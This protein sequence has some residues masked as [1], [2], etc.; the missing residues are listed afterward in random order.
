MDDVATGR[1]AFAEGVECTGASA[2]VSGA[3][4]EVL[5]V[6]QVVSA[7]SPGA[8]AGVSGERFVSPFALRICRYAVG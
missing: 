6:S 1:E 7:A 8:A 2:V 3:A 5:S 4:P